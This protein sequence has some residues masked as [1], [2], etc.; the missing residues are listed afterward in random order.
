MSTGEKF[1]PGDSP[2]FVGRAEE[3][4]ALGHA[5]DEARAGHGSGWVLAGPA[6]IGKT[7]LLGHMETL[8][9]RAGWSIRRSTALAGLPDPLFLLH[10]LFR[11]RVQDGVPE[12]IPEDSATLFFVEEPQ[13]RNVLRWPEARTPAPAH[14][15]WVVRENPELFRGRL[16]AALQE[17]P[18]LW[19]TRNEGVDHAPPGDL[20]RL[21]ERLDQV[22]SKGGTVVFLGL[23][24]VVTQNGFLPALR[25]IQHLRDVAEEG[26]GRVRVHLRPDTFEPRERALLVSEGEVWSGHP[27]RTDDALRAEEGPVASQ[28][29]RF[30]DTLEQDLREHPLALVIDDLQWADLASLQGLRLLLRNLASHPLLFLATL[31]VEGDSD[32]PPGPIADTLDQLMRDEAI[33]RLDLRGLDPGAVRELCLRRVSLPP[34]RLE[35]LAERLHRRTDGN[36]Y[37][38]TE[39][40]REGGPTLDLA[41]PGRPSEVP[42]SIRR[43]LGHRLERLPP[44]LLRTARAA[45]VLGLCFPEGLLRALHP[46]GHPQSY[47]WS[48][49]ELGTRYDLVFPDPVRAGYWTFANPLIWETLRGE[50]S[51]AQHQEIARA[52]ADFLARHQPGEIEQIARLYHEAGERVPG[53]EWARKASERAERMQAGAAMVTYV[54]WSIDLIGVGPDSA[55]ERAREQLRRGRALALSGR[56]EESVEY[57]RQLAERLPFGRMRWETLLSE[58]T[59]LTE[60]RPAEARNLLATLRK[61]MEAAEAPEDLRIEVDLGEADYHLLYGDPVVGEERAR[62]AI[63]RLGPTGSARLRATALDHEAWCARR[64]G[65]LAEALKLFREGERVA[66]EGGESALRAYHLDGIGNVLFLQGDLVGARQHAEDA[67]SLSRALGDYV[68]A[69]IHRTNLAILELH[70]GQPGLARASA[71]EALRLAERMDVPRARVGI[72]VVLARLALRERDWEE[73]RQNLG[74]AARAAQE[75]G[76][77]KMIPTVLALSCLL[78]G[79]SGPPGIALHQFPTAPEAE[80]GATL[81]RAKAR[82]LDL[83]GRTEEA[84]A[85]LRYAVKRDDLDSNPVSTEELRILLGRLLARQGAREEGNRLEAEGIAALR[86]MGRKDPEVIPWV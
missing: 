1:P 64:Q 2:P 80:A 55:E 22:L 16:P 83:N 20:D 28:W 12:L 23:E 45:S 77:S 35:D 78:E 15:L 3:I 59:G 75:L 18:F 60:L 53:L 36:P 62:R 7:R 70:L 48:L 17:S 39:L 50:L 41:E 25:L 19:L 8:A 58:V 10:Q 71:R 49:E 14:T 47:R 27:P 67:A 42:S 24:Y 63:E 81:L 73:A 85:V 74:L 21:A 69:S 54:D 32:A 65:H 5:L 30:Q 68:N 79:E 4:R 66:R 26:G 86:R 72:H 43:L 61:E 76:E 34:E 13:P 57:L 9:R 31:R 51:L 56:M 11:G 33:H 46:S 37:Y 82:L 40:L 6:G 84:E 38:V 29:F 52:F 44:E